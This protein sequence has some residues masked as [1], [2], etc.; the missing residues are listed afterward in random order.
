MLASHTICIGFGCLFFF[1]EVFLHLCC[2]LGGY[3]QQFVLY[4]GLSCSCFH[5]PREFNF[6]CIAIYFARLKYSQLPSHFTLYKNHHIFYTYCALNTPNCQ[7]PSAKY[8]KSNNLRKKQII[9]YCIYC[10]YDFTFA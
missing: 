2:C 8:E 10:I 7:P 3:V 1:E 4:I 9:F 6:S 5:I